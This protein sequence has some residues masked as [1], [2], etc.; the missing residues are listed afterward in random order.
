MN[1]AENDA[2]ASAPPSGAGHALQVRAAQPADRDV[3]LALRCA[4]WP[5]HVPLHHER[6]I[7]RRA[8]AAAR[9][10]TLLVTDGAGRPCGF[11]ELTRTASDAGA[12]GQ[13]LLDGVFVAPPARRRGAARRLLAA[14]EHWA[15]GRGAAL[16][17]CELDAAD[18]ASR[19]ALAWLGFGDPEQRVR[20]VRR[21]R[22]PLQVSRLVAAPGPP[23]GFAPAAHSARSGVR[24]IAVLVNLLLF[25][26][27]LA[28]FAHT[29]I[30]A[31]D[32]LRGVLL[33]LLDVL[34]VLYFMGVV[35]T[36][37]YRR[38]ADSSRR[39]ERLFRRDG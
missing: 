25:A 1:G 19:E 37:R 13:V 24:P 28:S 16:L 38:R 20:V 3:L 23:A 12:P 2:S 8:Q 7:R 6:E 17:V 4:L 29:D 30:Y 14:A 15:H 9:H 11:V 10:E 22:A 34:F 33:P 39:A 26:A 32:M 5:Q 21:V 31:R 35:L 27:A 18:T 36:W